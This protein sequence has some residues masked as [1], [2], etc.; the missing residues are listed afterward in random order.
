[1]AAMSRMSTKVMLIW[2]YWRQQRREGT[3][4]AMMMVKRTMK[5]MSTIMVVKATR[6]IMNDGAWGIIIEQSNLQLSSCN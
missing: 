6:I 4:I 2:S 5:I 3:M 1:M